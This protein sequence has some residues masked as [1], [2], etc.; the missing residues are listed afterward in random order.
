MS[1]QNTLRKI[2]SPPV[3]SEDE[4]KTRSAYYINVIA[5]VSIPALVAFLLFRI[6]QG[7][8]LLESSNLVLLALIAILLIVLTLMRSGAVRLAGYIHISTIW[9]A[10]TLLALTGSGIRG[11]GFVSYFV[12][13]LLAGLLLGER[14]GNQKQGTYGSSRRFRASYSRTHSIIG[15]TRHTDPNRIQYGKDDCICAGSGCAASEYCQ[16]S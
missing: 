4:N 6:S 12:V 16:S 3:F 10:S 15:K 9:L 8:G 7:N 2:F 14:T 13:M 5:L 11:S 1:M